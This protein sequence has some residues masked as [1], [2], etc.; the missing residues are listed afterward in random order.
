MPSF[1][2]FVY[3]A[4]IVSMALALAVIS[5]AAYGQRGGAAGAAAAPNADRVGGQFAG[6]DMAP[7][8]NEAW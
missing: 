6:F 5:G 1:Y 4:S 3:S 2:R 8:T 7:E